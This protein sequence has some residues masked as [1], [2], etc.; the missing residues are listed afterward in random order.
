[1]CS[2]VI[3]GVFLGEFAVK[4]IPVGD[5][6]QWLRGMMREVK[7]L[8]R[9]AT[10]PNIVSY[11]HS[12]LEMNRANELCPYVPYLFVLMS[13]CDSGSLEDL[14]ESCSLTDPTIW[15]LFLDT[16]KGL[17]HLHRNYILHRDLKL[18]NI[19]LTRDS[20]GLRA[21]LSDF[22]TAEIAGSTEASAHTGFTGTVEYTAPEVLSPGSHTYTEQS[23]MW[24]LGIILYAMCYGGVPYSDPDPVRC[25]EAI[26]GHSGE[27]V[28]PPSPVRDDDLK[29][30][31][32]AL[33]ARN[34]LTRPSCQD[35]LFHPFIRSKID[36][37]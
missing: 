28:F 11:K 14:V 13:Y 2:H 34:P 7:A 27:L 29:N 9:L 1:L 4:K 31:I 36:R 6:R 33:T 22:G 35:I 15:S 21:V 10:H 5:S 17:E 23:D 19:L 32:S 18:S 8:E 25:A 24:S 3:D 30:I 26:L 20:S 16:T 37:L 12:W